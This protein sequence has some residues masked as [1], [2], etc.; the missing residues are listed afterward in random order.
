MEFLEP[1]DE[2]DDRNGSFKAQL[3]LEVQ[4]GHQ[5]YQVPVQLL[6]RGNG[7]DCLFEILDGTGRVAQVHLV[8]Q[9]PQRPPWP[10]SQI[11]P[12][13]QTWR[14]ESM[15]PEHKEWVDQ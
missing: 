12:N 15:L 5:L 8:W 1:W 13:I 14:A 4:P 3:A 9:G 7:D 10:S 2:A 11:Y 6:A